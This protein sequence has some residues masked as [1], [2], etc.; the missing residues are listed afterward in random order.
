MIIDW[1]TVGAQALNFLVLVWLMRRFLYKPVLKAI[2]GREKRIAAQLS[3]ADSKLTEAHAERDEF[4]RKNADFDQERTTLM[5]NV[6]AEAETLRQQLRDETAE[7]ATAL[8]K[9]WRNSLST[10][11]RNL[12]ETLTRKTREEVFAI[13]R[14]T[15]SDLADAKLEKAIAKVLIQRL[16]DLSSEQMSLLKTAFASTAAPLVRSTFRLQPPEQAAIQKAIHETFSTDTPL[17][18]EISPDLIAGIELTIQG[19]KIAWSISEYLTSLEES[20]DQ[21]LKPSAKAVA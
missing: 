1:F 7:E 9:K 20:V 5:A 11:Q 21:I 19:Q 8:R 6:S 2:D 13:S 18:F 12:K 15:L 14:K 3:E 17:R 16:G 10:E 4:Q